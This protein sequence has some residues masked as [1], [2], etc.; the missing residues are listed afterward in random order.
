MTSLLLENHW[1]KRR[2]TWKDV[3]DILRNERKLQIVWFSAPFPQGVWVYN[4]DICLGRLPI[5]PTSEF[6]IIQMQGFWPLFPRL[7]FHPQIRFF[8]GLIVPETATCSAFSVFSSSFFVPGCTTNPN[9]CVQQTLLEIGNTESPHFTV[10]VTAYRWTLDISAL[11]TYLPSPSLRQCLMSLCVPPFPGL[12]TS[13]CWA[14]EQIR[15]Q[16]L[17]WVVLMQHLPR[18]NRWATKDFMLHL[19][20]AA[21]TLFWPIEVYQEW[22]ESGLQAL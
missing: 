11:D 2:M 19:H 21:A 13:L 12:P 7:W 17:L 4:P 15:K 10:W 16:C 3:C 20:W 1:Y 22:C 18:K 8:K 5:F 9:L 6:L 14:L